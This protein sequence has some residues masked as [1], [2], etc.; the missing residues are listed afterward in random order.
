MSA[1]AVL[2]AA[3]LVTTPRWFAHMLDPLREILL[4]VEKD[5]E[6]YR[7]AAFLDERSLRPD[8]ARQ[9]VEWRHVASA[10]GP[11]ARR[12]AH[13]IFHI[14]HV[15]STLISR[16]LGE[17][18]GFFSVRE[19]LILRLLAE[20]AAEAG[21]DEALWSPETLAGRID[22]ARALLSRTFRPEQR[23]IVKATSAASEIAPRLARQ[24]CRALLLYA[25]PERYAPTVLAGENSRRELAM[26][27]QDR[28]KRLHRRSGE[29]RWRLWEMDEGARLGLAWAV[30]MTSLVEAADEMRGS[31]I[32]LD[33][34][35][36]LA[37][38]GAA[39]AD[40]ALAFGGSAGEGAALAEHP[41]MRRYSKATEHEYSASLRDDLL[42]AASRDHA[43]VLAAALAWIEDAARDMPLVARALD[44]ADGSTAPGRAAS[45]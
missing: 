16:L 4:L 7:K 36:F 33:F 29:R 44:L 35:R 32:W 40:L 39:L 19:P 21:S 6:E 31:P 45:V 13:Y 30:E 1:P 5:E 8:R 20:M 34:D 43:G 28:L 2:S 9:A 10:F 23:A 15:G 3:D 18:P 22:V 37:D 27:S 12:D 38:P 24:G 17:I 14:G 41:L 42:A 25:R 11:P 26:A